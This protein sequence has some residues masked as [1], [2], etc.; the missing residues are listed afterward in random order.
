MKVA[1]VRPTSALR[2]TSFEGQLQCYEY[3]ASEFNFDIDVVCRS[4]EK[5]ATDV[6]EVNLLEVS[7]NPTE[8]LRHF[9]REGATKILGLNDN[10]NMP[11]FS[12]VYHLLQDQEYDVIE[13]SDPRL[14]KTA[15]HAYKSIRGTSTRLV[16]V[17]ST[18][19]NLPSPI[20][21]SAAEEVTKSASGILFVSPRAHESFANMG[22]LPSEDPY[23]EYTGHPINTEIFSPSNYAPQDTVTFLSVGFLEERKGYRDVCRAFGQVNE[24]VNY[25]WEIIGGGELKDWIREYA[26]DYGFEDRITFHG[27]VDHDDIS[28]YYD[29]ADVFILH[30]K[31][32]ENW[33]EYF[34]VVYAEA[35][36]SGLPII[37]SESGAVPWVVREGKDG[38]LPPEGDINQLSE[39]IVEFAQNPEKRQVYGQ[40]GRQNILSR[41]TVEIVAEKFRKAWTHNVA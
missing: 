10:I 25:E 38:I 21:Q 30:S 4:D 11:E 15:H 26:S 12:E 18:S 34:G 27:R 39:A 17:A 36:S 20:P 9:V 40:N 32:T 13:V 6:E 28:A 8:K 1:V 33:E 41:F 31:E 3:L 35:M 22:L 5:L 7:Q 19:K 24:D 37:G 16:L 23:V 29:K 2:N 14:Y